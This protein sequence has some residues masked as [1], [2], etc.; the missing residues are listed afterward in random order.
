PMTL[1]TTLPANTADV[2][3]E[4]QTTGSR[5]NFL[6]NPFGT[7]LDLTGI[8]S[9]PGGSNIPP[10]GP[11][12]WTYDP[13]AKTFVTGA[14]SVP[15]WT[16]FRVRSKGT[17]SAARNLTIPASAALTGG[18][19]VAARE[20]EA[21]PGLR[22]TLDGVDGDGTSRIADRS[23]AIGFSDEARAAFDADEDVE[24][25]QVPAESYALIGAR[26]GEA[27]LGY[28][29]RPFANA[30]IPLAIE[31]RGTGSRFTLR[32]DADALPAGLPV[33]LVDLVTGRE[34]D[35]RTQSS[36][37][38]DVRTLEAFTDVIPSSDFADGANA[39]DRFVLRI[40]T[41][42]SAEAAITEVEL[43]AIAPNPSTGA[44]RVSFALPEAGPARVT[45]YDVRGRS[46]A[47]LVDGPLS[48]GRHEATLDSGS[49]AAGVY[50]V[51]LEAAGAVVTRQAVVVR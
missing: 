27:F 31:A 26:A 36:V 14:T 38:F 30:E 11:Q 3:V 20:T 49:L 9:W 8:Y 43:T 15:A 12:V 10:T 13:V 35:V 22:F 21:V 45:V 1:T 5:M 24:K 23:F 39:T 2:T 46:V 17:G 33:V 34:I 18:A 29:A 25:F 47:T 28:D 6:A 16:G 44:A 40:G 32:W 41:S 19:R 50:V 51:R 48:A 7:D 42:A 37:S 4:L